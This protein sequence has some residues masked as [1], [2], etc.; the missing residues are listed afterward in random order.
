[1]VVTHGTDTLE[2]VALLCDLLYASEPPI[3]FTGA[4]RH[5]PPRASAC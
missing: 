2:E 1:V 3:V 5:G 4:M